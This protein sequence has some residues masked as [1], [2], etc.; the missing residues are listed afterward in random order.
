LKVDEFLQVQDNSKAPGTI[1]WWETVMPQLTEKQQDDLTQAA[2]ARNITHRTISIVLGQW[3][4]RVSA[5][6]VGHWRR[7]HVG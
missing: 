4:H 7:T 3:G 6:Q 2:A 5:A 1:G